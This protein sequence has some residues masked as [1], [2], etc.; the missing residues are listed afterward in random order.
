MP[1]DA[2]QDTATAPHV[3]LLRTAP[4]PDTL[5]AALEAQGWQVHTAGDAPEARRLASRHGCALIVLDMAMHAV[6]DAVAHLRER[7]AL[8]LLVLAGRCSPGIRLAALA[9]GADAW[10]ARPCA[11]A[12]V[13][14]GVV[15]LAA[16]GRARA[17]ALA[18]AR[19]QEEVQASV[20]AEVRAEGQT[21][22]QPLRLDDLVLDRDHG[23]C[24]RDDVDLGLTTVEFALLHALLRQPG[25]VL[26]RAQLLAQVW[27]RHDDRTANVVE[28][29]ICRLRHKLDD[30]FDAKLLHTVRGAGY[31]LERRAFA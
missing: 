9:M 16:P 13:L 12:D 24:S 22:A 8:P 6:P 1:V 11:T 30:A 4:L 19:R 15:A 26:T 10:L 5:S 31:V 7:T 28:A 3:L 2:R 25:R 29:S 14:A 27:H 21:T 20:Q 18:Q 23:R 17:R